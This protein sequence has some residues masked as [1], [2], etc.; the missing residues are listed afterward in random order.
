M[1]LYCSYNIIQTHIYILLY[2]LY[3]TS[4]RQLY[5]LL[6][7]TQFRACRPAD[8]SISESKHVYHF[9]N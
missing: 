8:N 2:I 9:Y 6:Q 3:F 4:E 1:Y 7:Y 5:G